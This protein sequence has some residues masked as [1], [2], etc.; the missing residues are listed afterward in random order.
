MYIDAYTCAMYMFM[1]IN[2]YGYIASS[3]CGLHM[4]MWTGNYA[5]WQS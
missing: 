3:V 5:K 4:Y 1:Y 2:M